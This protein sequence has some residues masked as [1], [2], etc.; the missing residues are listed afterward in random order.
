MLRQRAEPLWEQ[1][2]LH[3]TSPACSTREEEGAKGISG[4]RL[5]LF[6][7]VL[8]TLATGHELPWGDTCLLAKNMQK[9][10]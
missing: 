6:C 9:L 1:L 7:L 5:L 2:A 8:S 10:L 4:Y 3:P